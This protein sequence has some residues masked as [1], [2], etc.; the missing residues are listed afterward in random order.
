[1]YCRV[2]A[3][4]YDGTVADGGSIAPEIG[5]VLE[6][7]RARGIV[8]LLVT[9]R[10]LEDLRRGRVD[11]SV[12]DAV[13]AEN[14]AVVHLP[15]SGR[16]E[17]L[18][19]PPS[20]A[21]LGALR[22][23]GVPFRAGT[24]VVATTEDHAAAVRGVIRSCGIDAQ[25]VFNRSALMLLPSGLNKAVGVRHA[26]AALGRSER[27]MVAFGDAENDHPL[28]AAAELA[29]AARGAVPAI[30]A[31]ADECL[32]APN[33]EGIARFVR[34][35]LERQCVVPTP[36]RQDVVLG[37]GAGREPVTL[38]GSGTNVM[39]SGDPK[40]GK[41]WVAGLVMERLLDRGYRLCVLDPEGDYLPL[42]S[43]PDVLA[44]GEQLALPAPAA[45]P[46]LLQR[47]PLS[48]VLSLAHLSQ[49]DRAGYAQAT[50]AALEEPRRLTGIPHWIVVDEAHEMLREG[51]PACGCDATGVGSMLLVTYRPSLMARSVHA[52]V[53][54]HLIER[55]TVEEERYFVTGLL[56]ARGPRGL[57][58]ADALRELQPPCTGLLL[59]SDTGPLWRVFTPGERDVDHRHHG[60]QYDDGAHVPEQ[61]A[62]RFVAPGGAV[63]ATVRTVRDFVSA[64]QTVSP[65]TLGRHLERGDF[66][67]WVRDVLGDAVLAARLRRLE[68]SARVGLAPAREDIVDLV[69][70]RY[71]L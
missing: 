19:R 70:Q 26:L 37:I 38:P 62:F 45:I 44:M 27:N 43:R 23:A 57:Q 60:R 7:A 71:I 29:V 61:R 41:S 68:Q 24:I 12:F 1:M 5:A 11:L 34:Q 58:A 51:S 15:A 66:S 49:P 30:A 40:A 18:G 53:R 54:A 25:L 16:T 14:G 69:R 3:C 50:L 2:I 64:V 52:A 13:V 33:G 22:D 31:I 10:V 65:A 67:R 20:A 48:I 35:L 63:V 17:V 21:V 47:H 6:A 39:V 56:Q 59:E 32:S 28:L 46:E 36:P 55:T 8:S 42:G 4:D 9:G